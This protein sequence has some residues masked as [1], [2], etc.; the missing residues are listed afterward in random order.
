MLESGAA[1][2]STAVY[3]QFQALQK[4]MPSLQLDR[5]TAGE[6]NIRFGKGNAISMGTVLVPTISGKFLLHVAPVNI[7]FLLCIDDMDRLGIVFD[8]IKNFL[9]Q[10]K[11]RCAEAIRL[12]RIDVYQ[13]PP[14]SIV[15]DAGNQLASAVFK[16]EA[17]IIG[18]KTKEVP[19][20]A[21]QSVGKVERYH[22]TL[23]RAYEVIKGDIPNTSREEI[24]QMA[25]KAINN[26]AGPNAIVPT[27][28][29]FGAFPRLTEESSP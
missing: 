21:H 29:V 28:F 25:V 5:S 23:R 16:Q 7:P 19:I 11:T 27:P 2:V 26:T 8:N 24:L 17:K 14:E 13:G 18:P 3:P 9:K 10:G 22:A 20:E 15:Y 1:G 4:L 6:H 12:C